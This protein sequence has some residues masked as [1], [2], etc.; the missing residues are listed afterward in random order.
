VRSASGPTADAHDALAAVTGAAITA[1]RAGASTVRPEDLDAGIEAV[2]RPSVALGRVLALSESRRRLLYELVSLS[3][4][5]RAS[6]SAA[7]E[8]IASREG[9]RSVPVDGAARA[10]RTR[11]RGPARPGDC[12]PERREGTTPSRLVPRFPTLVFQ[13]LF[14]RPSWSA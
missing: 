14:D 10:L 8:T 11:R 7:T 9:G 12:P 1:E 6:V 2:P 13:E 4:D 5:D 3:D